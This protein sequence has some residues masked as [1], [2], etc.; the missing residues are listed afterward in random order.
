[1][2]DMTFMFD[3]ASSFDQDIG[4]WNVSNVLD[5]TAMFQNVWLSTPNYDSLLIGWSQLTL[6]I[7]VSFDGGLSQYSSGAAADARAYIISTFN[8]TIRDGHVYLYIF[9]YDIP[10]MIGIGILSVLIAIVIVKKRSSIQ[11]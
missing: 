4:G 3:S 1:V 7:G 8:W 6:Q 10:T 11:R 2:T 9:G 5:M